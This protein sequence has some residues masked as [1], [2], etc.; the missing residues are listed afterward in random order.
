MQAWLAGEIDGFAADA[1]WYAGQPL[2][3]TENDYELRL[4]NGDSGVI[5]ADGPDRVSAAFERAGEIVAYSPLR[6][7]AV[8]TLYAMT[9]H[10][11]QGSQFDTAA[12]VLPAPDSRILTRELLYTAAT[13]ARERL[14]LLGSE[15]AI[16]AAVL[17][18]ISRASGLR[19]RLWGPT[20]GTRDASPPRA[21]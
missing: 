15:E 7:G 1:R 10:K 14:L 11:S 6:L 21:C 4:Y 3:V 8:Q 18:P 13:R 9:V 12:V 20:D 2:L 5:V 16:R 17:R 19:T